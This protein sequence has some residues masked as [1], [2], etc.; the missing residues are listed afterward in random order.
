MSLIAPYGYGPSLYV[1]VC[2]L[3]QNTLGN[4]SMNLSLL[5]RSLNRAGPEFKAKDFASFKPRG[6]TI[7]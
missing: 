4:D 1:P 6:T 7:R 5:I 2:L 3:C